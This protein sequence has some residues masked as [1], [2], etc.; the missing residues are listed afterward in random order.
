MLGAARSGIGHFGVWGWA[1]HAWTGRSTDQPRTELLVRVNRH[2][3][4]SRLEKLNAMQLAT[5]VEPGVW[6]LSPQLKPIL[7]QLGERIDTLNLIS[8]ALG[9][10][11]GH[12]AVANYLI[13]RDVPRFPVTGHLVGKGLAGDGLGDNAYLVID[14]VDARLHYIELSTSQAPDE[15]CSGAIL[16]VG[17]IPTDRWVDKTIASYAARSDGYYQPQVH[18][19]IARMTGGIPGGDV[20]DHIEGHVPRLEALRRA[21]IVNRL[22]ANHW[23][24]PADFLERAAAFDAHRRAPLY[25]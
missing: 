20:E 9:E 21:G 2:L 23:L 22:D 3:L 10:A 4:I 16:T 12:R 14:G 5:P 6:H 25:R 11:A 8:D 17:R 13:H 18:D 15:A 7:I 1:R 24:S 19:Q